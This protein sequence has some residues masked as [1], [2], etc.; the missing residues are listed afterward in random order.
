[1][2]ASFRYSRSLALALAVLMTA[3]A[4]ACAGDE[5]GGNTP[6][7]TPP[8]QT[9]TVQPTVPPTPTRTPGPGTPTASPSAVPSVTPTAATTPGTP[10]PVPV[11]GTST[12]TSTPIAFQNGGVVLP[13]TQGMLELRPGAGTAIEFTAEDVDVSNFRAT[14]TFANPFHPDD[15]PWNYGLKFREDGGFYQMLVFDHRGRI[16]YLTGNPLTVDLVSTTDIAEFRTNA[17]QSNK[18]TLMVLEEMAWIYING[19]LAKTMTVGAVGVSGSISLVTDIYNETTVQ[20]ASVSFNSFS[21]NSAGLAGMSPGG[22]LQKASA[23]E[24]AVGP[25]SLPTS[26]GYARVTIVSPIAAFSGD[27]SFGL[28]FKSS[29]GGI[30]NWLVFDD[31]KNWQHIRR[32]SAGG[33]EVLA[34]GTAQMLKTG[35]SEPNT[36]EVLS[37]EGQQRVYVNGTLLTALNFVQGDLPVAI[38]PFAGFLPA[39]QPSGLPTE[40]RDFVVWSIL[41]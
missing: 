23:T 22:T 34:S 9:A 17:G 35:Q 4:V 5:P 30:E 40:Y 13:V 27:Y 21:I 2:L 25:A 11:D 32:S 15:Y 1:M 16:S 29:S 14:V 19:N 33:E 28:F 12:P 24:I 37:I 26:A 10:T 41:R 3:V 31:L 7:S 20:N 38:A 6:T 18:I 36:F 8:Q 39:H